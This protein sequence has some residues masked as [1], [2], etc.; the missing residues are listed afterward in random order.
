LN[1]VL[2]RVCMVGVLLMGCGLAQ[3]PRA[4][5]ELLLRLQQLAQGNDPSTAR[6]ELDAAIKQFPS[7]PGLYNLR[8][9]VEAQQ[10]NP[11]AAET[12]F[13]K[14]LAVEPDFTG[15]SMNLGRLYLQEAPNNPQAVQDALAVY[16]QVLRHEPG[17]EE[18]I[19]QSAALLS[20][21]GSF[22]E[23][24]DD[25]DRLSPE[26]AKRAPSLAI[27]CADRR[28]LNQTA[29]AF[30]SAEELLRAPD[31]AEE[32]VLA[33][34]PQI[35]G[36]DQ[37]LA[38]RLLEGLVT[39]Q[40]A[41][42]KSLQQL[43]QLYL[44]QQRPAL[45]RDTLEQ[46]E[47]AG[48]PSAEILTELGRVAYD[49]HDFNGALG[50]LA[51]ARDLDPNS[52]SIHFFF[53]VVCIELNLPLEATK[54]LQEAVRLD[55]ENAYYNFAL[56]S[57]LLQGRD[58]DHAVKCFLKYVAL[59]PADPRGKFALGVAQFHVA[60][61][62]AAVA[63]LHA[64][65]ESKE[66][67]AGAHYFLGRIARAQ[68][69]FVTAESELQQSVAADPQF[70]DALAELAFVHIRQ[71]RTKEATLELE[72]AFALDPDNFRV[73]ANLL[74]LYQKTGDPRAPEQ[75]ARFEEIKKKRAEDEQSLWRTIEIRP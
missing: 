48:S 32:D 7:E 71:Q 68:D 67:A 56:G 61:Y 6:R 33:A 26:A 2:S 37:A 47:Q 74:V 31:L 46:A 72:R 12:D 1:Q 54:S 58:Q 34:L 40:L 28:G 23:S 55:P 38:V 39:R 21:S 49:Q 70:V 30:S 36:R 64:A 11:E 53:G 27:R 66:S 35:S 14:A 52:A 75:A 8:G 73:N 69:D 13:R 19:Y 16:Q 4:P 44:Q 15:A 45:A 42:R 20:T 9:I 62:A 65:S 41:G 29:L 63:N 60:D 17:N 43:G 25:L 51:H 3:V 10:N 22:R 18:A 50:Y 24:L 5:H 59:R 57:V